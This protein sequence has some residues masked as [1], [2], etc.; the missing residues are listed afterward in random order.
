MILKKYYIVTFNIVKFCFVDIF[1]YMKNHIMQKIHMYSPI[2][3]AKSMYNLNVTRQESYDTMTKLE[4]ILPVDQASI[5]VR[6]LMEDV[7]NPIRYSLFK[8][9]LKQI[10]SLERLRYQIELVG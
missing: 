4:G 8:E 10:K 7:S 5:M 2:G 3:F 6:L 1:K 9:S